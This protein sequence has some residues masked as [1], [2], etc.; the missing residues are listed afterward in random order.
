M[1]IAATDLKRY[2]RNM[3]CDTSAGVSKGMFLGGLRLFTLIAGFV[4]TIANLR[5][6]SMTGFFLSDDLAD[7][8]DHSHD[9]VETMWYDCILQ[10]VIL[11]LWVLYKE[12][13]K[14]RNQVVWCAAVVLFKSGAIF[15]FLFFQLSKL[16]AEEE[17]ETII[18]RQGDSQR[19]HGSVFEFDGLHPMKKRFR[20]KKK[21]EETSK[22]DVAAH[23]AA[24]GKNGGGDIEDD[25]SDLLDF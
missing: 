3:F 25:A 1:N 17:I 5:A 21:K 22:R 11:S 16:T 12:K 24:D 2:A 8:K 9:W 18:F 13:G 14:V 20:E 6:H 23:A 4:M 15:L 19:R 7:E 10:T